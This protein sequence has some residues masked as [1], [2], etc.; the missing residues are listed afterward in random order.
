MWWKLWWGRT[1]WSD[2]SEVS[3]GRSCGIAESGIRTKLR[4]NECRSDTLGRDRLRLPWL[5]IASG[6]TY[7]EALDLECEYR[8]REAKKVCQGRKGQERRECGD[9]GLL[10]RV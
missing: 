5:E 8:R 6:H 3:A 2:S 9:A 10:G 7:L 4:R 1:R